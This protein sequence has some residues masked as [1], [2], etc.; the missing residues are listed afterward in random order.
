MSEMDNT[1]IAEIV[2]R[3]GLGY[4][5]QWYMSGKNFKDKYLANLWDETKERLDEIEEILE[6]AS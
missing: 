3:E 2:E 1:E 6:N 4:A 5:V